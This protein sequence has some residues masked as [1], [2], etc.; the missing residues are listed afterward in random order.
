MVRT[1]PWLRT[2]RTP[3]FPNRCHKSHLRASNLRLT[4][5]IR[6]ISCLYERYAT[7]F[8]L[9]QL[10]GAHMTVVARDRQIENAEY[11][12]RM[13]V[14]AVAASFITFLAVSGYWIVTTLVQVS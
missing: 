11:R 5:N 6:L 2:L 4:E 12:Q 9:T 13:M 8:W 3:P 14:N 10:I 7:K 1:S